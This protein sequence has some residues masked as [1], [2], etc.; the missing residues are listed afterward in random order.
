MKM[1][2]LATMD[3]TRKWTG[4]IQN[5]GQTQTKKTLRITALKVKFNITVQL[6]IL[7]SLAITHPVRPYEAEIT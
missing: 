4:R 7:Y 6:K 2:Y 1:L 3:V 5:W